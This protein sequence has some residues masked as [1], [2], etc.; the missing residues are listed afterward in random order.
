MRK[1]LPIIILAAFSAGCAAPHKLAG[2]WN[3]REIPNDTW[4]FEE[5]GTFSVM[6]DNA[7]YD[8]GTYTVHDHALRIRMSTETTPDYAIVWLDP[9]RFYLSADHVA[10]TLSRRVQ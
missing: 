7:P 6:A 10:L 8:S 1:L 3:I 2:T 9:D 5:N 4:T